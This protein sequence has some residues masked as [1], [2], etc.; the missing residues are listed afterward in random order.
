LKTSKTNCQALFDVIEEEDMVDN[1]D[2]DGRH[3]ALAQALLCS[4]TDGLH[5]LTKIALSCKD[6]RS[7]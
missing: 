6:H 4:A 7:Q 1:P 3:G 2:L 5:C